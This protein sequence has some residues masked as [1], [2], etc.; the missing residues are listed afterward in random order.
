MEVQ[1]EHQMANEMNFEFGSSY[2]SSSSLKR[3]QCSCGC[4]TSSGHYRK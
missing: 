4:L 1:L 2:L 3:R